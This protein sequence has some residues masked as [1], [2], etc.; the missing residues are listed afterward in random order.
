MQN[1][2][3]KKE[4]P[5]VNCIYSLAMIVEGLALDCNDTNAHT[6][7]VAMRSKIVKGSS[8]SFGDWSDGMEEDVLSLP[9][10]KETILRACIE[11]I[12]Q[13]SRKVEA[14]F[15][16]EDARFDFYQRAEIAAMRPKEVNNNCYRALRHLI[17]ESYIK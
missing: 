5:R 16:K 15:R 3:I 17:Y 1:K 14:G 4:S 11:L 8:E 13:L 6:Q 9:F 7:A 12:Y 10:N 2:I